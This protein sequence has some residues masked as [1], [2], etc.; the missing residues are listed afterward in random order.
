MKS[1]LFTLLV[2]A[3]AILAMSVLNYQEASASAKGRVNPLAAYAEAD[4]NCNGC[5]GQKQENAGAPPQ[6]ASAVCSNTNG[7]TIS[8]HAIANATAAPPFWQVDVQ[9][10]G[11][12]AWE[13]YGHGKGE[14]KVAFVIL[15]D[16][17][18]VQIQNVIGNLYKIWTKG[19]MTMYPDGLTD[20]WINVLVKVYSSTN[21][22]TPIRSGEI[23]LTP[24][25]KVVSG[26]F[27]PDSFYYVRGV[28]D[29]LRYSDTDTFTYIGDIN[30]LILE[31]SCPLRGSNVPTTTQW[32]VCILVGLIV[33]SGVFIMLRRKKAAVPA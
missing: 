9:E 20:A 21:P 22:A 14:E 11:K 2:I 29:T 30:N 13:D 16:T 15:T 7:T 28:T 31:A 1:R 25:Q 5:T 26:F 18:T 17:T 4:C 32:G 12:F 19:K 6:T 8:E 27:H 33:T 23:R 24:G 10:L 3:G